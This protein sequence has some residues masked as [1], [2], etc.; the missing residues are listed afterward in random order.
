[1]KD[2][3]IPYVLDI[4]RDGEMNAPF[5]LQTFAPVFSRVGDV[6]KKEWK[7]CVGLDGLDCY[8]C[9]CFWRKGGG[10]EGRKEGRGD[11]GRNRVHVDLKRVERRFLVPVRF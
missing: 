3:D 4:S 10:K 2:S 9:S 6:K 11:G 8:S 1:M 7:A 5:H